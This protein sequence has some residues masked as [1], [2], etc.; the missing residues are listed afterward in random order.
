MEKNSSKL[1]I[2]RSPSGISNLLIFYESQFY[3]IGQFAAKENKRW[4]QFL[5]IKKEWSSAEGDIPDSL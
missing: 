4:E 2:Q 1:P 5:V 3:V